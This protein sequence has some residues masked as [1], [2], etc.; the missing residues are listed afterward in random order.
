MRLSKAFSLVLL[1]AFLLVFATPV[2]A[3]P[4]DMYI[5]TFNLTLTP[6]G[7]LVNWEIKPGPM[8]ASWLWHE[9]DQDQDETISPEEAHAWGAVRTALLTVS[10]D[11]APF[12]A[13][14]DEV[15]FP[16]TLNE[17]QS[18]GETILLTL[19]ASWP[20][21]GANAHRLILHNG[22]EEQSSV[23]WFTLQAIESAAF[24]QPAHQGSQLAVDF[25]RERE[26]AGDQSGLLTTWDS[27]TPALPPGQEQDVVMSTAEQVIPEL[28]QESPQE[29]LIGLVRREQ[30]SVAFYI[31]ALGISL[32]LGALH[33][34]TPGHGKTIVAAYLVGTRGTVRHAIAL[35]SIV[36]LTHTGSV[37]LLGVITLV[38][39]RYIL[40]T[41]LIPALEVLS[42]LLILGLGMYLLFQRIRDWRAPKSTHLH[43]HDHAHDHDHS[44]AHDHDHEHGH[45]HQIPDSEAVTWRSLV[46]LGVSGGLV[47]CPDAI[48]ILL[49]A[50]AINRL[51]LGLSLILAFS[52]G[53]ALV[54]IVIGLTIVQGSHL[55]R[56]MDSFSRV[57]SALPVISALIVLALG[58]ALT[59]GA[60]TRFGSAQD[61]SLAGILP[62]EAPS[63]AET[64]VEGTAA[65]PITR[66]EGLSLEEAQ[67]VHLSE[68]EDGHK[69]LVVSGTEGESGRMLT[70]FPRGVRDYALSPDRSQVVTVGQAADLSVSLW[71]TDVN[72]GQAREAV[73][74]APADCS[75]P[76]WSPDGSKVVYEKLDL[77]AEGGG[78][79]LPTLWWLDTA[80]GESR[81]VFQEAQLPGINPRWSPDGRWLSYSTPDGGVRLYNLVTGENRI[82]KSLLGTAVIWS[83]DSETLL[84]RDVL[85]QE[86]GFITH[87]Y[88]YDLESGEMIDLNDDPNQENNLAAWAPDGEWLA[89]VRRDLSVAMGDQIW[90]MRADGSQAR[91]LTE[92]PN[93]LH[94]SLSWSPDGRYILFDGYMLDFFPLEA[95]LQVVDVASGEVID[96][97]IKG[98]SPAW[99]W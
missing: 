86:Q 53:L 2:Q 39:S 84:L 59:W 62:G 57:A 76:V 63:Q 88:H 93:V 13:R 7:L 82:L 38:A 32:A 83:P 20:Q 72:G 64:R 87:L 99:I 31:L 94:G 23:N 68:D 6:Q 79:G 3:H 12:P 16:A 22:V 19:S 14:L 1:T 69:Q 18:S 91:Q 45:T 29:I 65:S 54:L 95:R 92:A 40:P 9:A 27:G 85:T 66:V 30:F 21:D 80:S 60:L 8:L 36:T 58:A 90:L 15:R 75:Q 73:R 10:L 71:L 51:V 25:L 98:Y 49:V 81:P 26:L 33:A 5:Q 48:A 78:L 50:V 34:L 11:D 52:L 35:G 56:K 89:V 43:D 96:L 61:L 47:P 70:D 74:C 41:R 4:A 17:L 24:R 77:S 67:I 42:G 97:G 44:H 46:A 28:A 55:F 37:L